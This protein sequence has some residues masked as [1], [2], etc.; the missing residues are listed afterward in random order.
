[1]FLVQA[2]LAQQPTPI[3]PDPNK[4][5]VSSCELDRLVAWVAQQ[6]GLENV[7][8]P[9]VQWPESLPNFQ[10]DIAN[11]HLAEWPAIRDMLS[12]KLAMAMIVAGQPPLP[13]IEDVRWRAAA[14]R[15]VLG[16]IKEAAHWKPWIEKRYPGFRERNVAER[17]V[18]RWQWSWLREQR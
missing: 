1:M 2:V 4:P 3:L 15:L 5:F 7:D 9:T 8:S 18:G 6:L 14:Q 12:G 17:E 16:P 10:P 13:D 11:R